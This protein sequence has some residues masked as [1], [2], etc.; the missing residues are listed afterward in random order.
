LPSLPPL[1]VLVAD[2]NR[3]AA[4]ILSLV[5]SSWGMEP[6]VAYDG[7]SA[8][9]A[10]ALMPPDVVLLDIRMPGADGW[11]VALRLRALPGLSGA[12]VL[13]LTGLSSPEDAARSRAAGID[14]HLVKPVEPDVLRLLIEE[15]ARATPPAALRPPHGAAGPSGH[16]PDP[17]GDAGGRMSPV[18]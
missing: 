8:L 11:E 17:R 4:D 2:D 10:A 7:P 14:R 12:L 1:R 15:H 16:A 9:G 13:A 6:I 5:L 3:D 18:G